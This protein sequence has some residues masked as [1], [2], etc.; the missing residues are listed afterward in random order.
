MMNGCLSV[1]IKM[2]VEGERVEYKYIQGTI[3]FVCDECISI[4]VSKGEHSSQDV[5]VVVGRSDFK[6]VSYLDSK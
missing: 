5:K 3:A 2:F 6:N 4:L 1:F